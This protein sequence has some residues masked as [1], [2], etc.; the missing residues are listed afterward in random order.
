MN[1]RNWLLSCVLLVLA[2]ALTVLASRNNTAQTAVVAPSVA[3]AVTSTTAIPVA[4]PVTVDPK[5]EENL[6]KLG[7]S[8]KQAHAVS[9]GVA[10][11]A[12][13]KEEVK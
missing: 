12:V 1:T 8:M 13:K 7:F 10:K 2:T 6:N 4:T 5:I 11:P 3:V 9:Y